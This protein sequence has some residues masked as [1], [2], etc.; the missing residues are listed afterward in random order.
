MKASAKLSAV[1]IELV[2]HETN[3]FRVVPR[4]VVFIDKQLHKAEAHARC[5]FAYLLVN[6]KK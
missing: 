6:T 1:L 5:F 4:L 2:E 3:S